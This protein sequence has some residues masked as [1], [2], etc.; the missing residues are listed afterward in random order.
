MYIK[1]MGSKTFYWGPLLYD[2]YFNFLLS[3]S[4]GK[5]IREKL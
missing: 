1:C 3:Q 4:D 2:I 5:R